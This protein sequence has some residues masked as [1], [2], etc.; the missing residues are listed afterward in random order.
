MGREALPALSLPKG[1]VGGQDEE[2]PWLHHQACL[3]EAVAPGG[4]ETT[5]PEELGRPHREAHSV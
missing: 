1:R 4:V 2:G 5:S 3:K